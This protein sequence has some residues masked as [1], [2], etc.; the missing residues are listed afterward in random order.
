M[1]Q[2]NAILL[3]IFVTHTARLIL[4]V[5]NALY[6]AFFGAPPTIHRPF[7]LTSFPVHLRLSASSACFQPHFSV[8]R[9]LLPPLILFKPTRRPC[10]PSPIPRKTFW[11]LSHG[12]YLSCFY[13]KQRI[14]KLLC[15][16]LIIDSI[17]KQIDITVCIIII[18]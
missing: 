6:F 10:L 14:Q 15:T 3:L 1:G 16:V 17:Y 18:S 5:R 2:R 9:A 4:F 7:A 12:L 8:R 13:P 11:R